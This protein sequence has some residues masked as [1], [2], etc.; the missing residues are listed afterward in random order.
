MHEEGYKKEVAFV[1]SSEERRSLVELKKKRKE[2][3]ETCGLK[4]GAVDCSIWEGNRINYSL[5]CM[6]QRH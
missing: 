4:N 5:K 6:W 3:M 1:L 2:N